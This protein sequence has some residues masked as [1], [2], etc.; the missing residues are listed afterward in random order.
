MHDGVHVALQ[1]S[2]PDVGVVGRCDGGGKE[3][4]L[5]VGCEGE[6][7]GDPFVL[8]GQADETQCSGI[9]GERGVKIVAHVNLRDGHMLVL[10]LRVVVS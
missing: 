9:V 10:Q 3:G 4:V 2:P 7:A 8:P 5:Q 1:Y 6:D